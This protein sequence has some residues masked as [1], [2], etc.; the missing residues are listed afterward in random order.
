MVL[1]ET[2]C[3]MRC[4]KQVLSMT[5]GVIAEYSLASSVGSYMLLKCSTENCQKVYCPLV[6]TDM[7]CPTQS[8]LLQLHSCAFYHWNCYHGVLRCRDVAVRM[9]AERMKY[10]QGM[11]ASQ[12]S[13]NAC[14]CSEH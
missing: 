2:C 8:G 14:S 7:Y 11:V 6:C 4:A 1:Q 3:R 5:M 10:Q 13:K 9:S 12:S